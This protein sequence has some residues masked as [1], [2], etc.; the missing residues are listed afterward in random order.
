MG[1]F[2]VECSLFVNYYN[3]ILTNK[4]YDLLS[5]RMTMMAEL[6]KIGVEEGYSDELHEKMMIIST[7]PDTH[8]N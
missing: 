8:Y 3:L 4:R 5:V 7:M 6:K 1:V 2:E